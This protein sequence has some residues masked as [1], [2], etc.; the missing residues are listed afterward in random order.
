[1]L[2][3]YLSCCLVL[4]SV[5]RTGISQLGKV[6]GGHEQRCYACGFF[7][8]FASEEAPWFAFV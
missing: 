5:F 4:G 8:D 1:M 2:F 6:E 3:T 7:S